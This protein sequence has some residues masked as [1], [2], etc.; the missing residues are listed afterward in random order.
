MS[1]S[2]PPDSPAAESTEAIVITSSVPSGAVP[3]PATGGS[4]PHS[5]LADE[6]ARVLS[7]Y[8]GTQNAVQ[9]TD[10]QVARGDQLYAT[11]PP[12]CPECRGALQFEPARFVD[13][14]SVRAVAT[15]T[16]CG[17]SG[18]GRF[19][20]VDLSFA[21]DEDSERQSMVAAGELTPVWEQY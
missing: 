5:D 12:V 8:V 4:P 17:V 14:K 21:T 18:S 6:I 11:V 20:L 7:Q 9:G 2:S 19:E 1:T 10:V 3:G 15:C 16:D 13:P